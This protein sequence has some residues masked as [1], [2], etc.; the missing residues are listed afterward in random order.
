[1]LFA[2]VPLEV[3]QAI[4]ALLNPHAVH[5]LL[6]QDGRIRVSTCVENAGDSDLIGNER[7]VT[8]D[9]RTD[10]IWVRRLNSSWGPHWKCQELALESTKDCGY[11]GD[12]LLSSCGA[13]VRMPLVCKRMLVVTYGLA[14]LMS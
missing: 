6:Q 10:K 5:I 3:R 1:M 4:F 14:V 9:W 8:G 7:Q 11:Q 13:I 2:L 12:D